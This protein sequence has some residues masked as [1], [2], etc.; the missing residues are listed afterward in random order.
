MEY[1]YSAVDYQ[2]DYWSFEISFFVVHRSLGLEQH[3]VRIYIVAG[4][5]RLPVS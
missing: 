3:D 4:V 1:F 2:K 5:V